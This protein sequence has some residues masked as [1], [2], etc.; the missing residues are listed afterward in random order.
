MAM[1]FM[2]LLTNP[3]AYAQNPPA[4]LWFG[5]LLMVVPFGL[6]GLTIL[7]ALWGAVRC[8]AGEDFRYVVIGKWLQS[9]A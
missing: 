5:L 4:G 2:P 1:L 9:G 7:Y 6:W 3:D 8:L